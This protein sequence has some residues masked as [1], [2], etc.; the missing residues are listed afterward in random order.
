[1]TLSLLLLAAVPAITDAT[2][3]FVTPASVPVNVP[4]SAIYARASFTNEAVELR[5]STNVLAACYGTLSGFLERVCGH[6][7]TN[8]AFYRAHAADFENAVRTEDITEFNDLEDRAPALSSRLGGAGDRTNFTSRIVYGAIAACKSDVMAVPSSLDWTYWTSAT[9]RR[10]FPECDEWTSTPLQ[11]AAT[12]EW[13][14]A[15]ATFKA[16]SPDGVWKTSAR[17]VSAPLNRFLDLWEAF[18]LHLDTD[19]KQTIRDAVQT[20]TCLEAVTNICGET[21]YALTNATT[22]LAVKP[23]GALQSAITAIDTHY[24]EGINWSF[25]TA[26]QD[27]T[28]TLS[29]SMADDCAATVTYD[30]GEEDDNCGV[31]MNYTGQWTESDTVSVTTNQTQNMS[32]P[33]AYAWRNG[34]TGRLVANGSGT[35]D[36]TTDHLA[37]L[38]ETNDTFRIEIEYR[39]TRDYCVYASRYDS[40]TTANI[41]LPTTATITR[42][43]GYSAIASRRTK[44]TSST[45]ASFGVREPDGLD[46]SCGLVRGVSATWPQVRLILFRPNESW[47]GDYLDYEDDR[48]VGSPYSSEWRAQAMPAVASE[49]ALY[50]SARTVILN[51]NEDNLNAF[52]DTF[53]FRV[54]SAASTLEIPNN[55]MTRLADDFRAIGRW[56]FGVHLAVEDADVSVTNNGYLVTHGTNVTY[57]T[58][59]NPMRIG[60]VTYSLDYEEDGLPFP[61]NSPCCVERSLNDLEAVEWNF[62]NL[63]RQ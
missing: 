53:G 15:F 46:F 21:A 37:I 62:K 36:M 32:W 49:Q 44:Y 39:P 13:A 27:L 19:E 3:F 30:V 10:P 35:L 24:A 48:E 17:A 63:S 38:K 29:H 7:Y 28:R 60:Y 45:L 23:L 57:V 2:Q 6:T 56:V 54:D 9:M 52:E 55:V 12:N 20:H 31:I 61:T 25:L 16:A 18:G 40:F 50:S 41:P 51:A 1:M 26:Y 58:N 4:A 33:F 34:G 5:A 11:A 22:R 8:T 59:E 47:Q 14:D 42:G 43:S